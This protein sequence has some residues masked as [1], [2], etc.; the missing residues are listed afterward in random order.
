MIFKDRF[1]SFEIRV[2]KNGW[3]NFDLGNQFKKT[4]KIIIV[5]KEKLLM[6]KK[7]VNKSL[8]LLK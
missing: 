6:I 1:S 3:F 8:K 5:D 2:G 7:A 4:G